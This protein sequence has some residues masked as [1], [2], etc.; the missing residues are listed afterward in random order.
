MLYRFNII[1]L[2]T[3]RGQNQQNTWGGQGPA[4]NVVQDRPAGWAGGQ[5][6]GGGGQ[7]RGGGGG[8]WSG[9][10]RQDRYRGAA[11]RGQGSGGGGGQSRNNGQ[12]GGARDRYNAYQSSGPSDMYVNVVATRA[13]TTIKPTTTNNYREMYHYQAHSCPK[14]DVATWEN[15]VVIYDNV[16]C[17]M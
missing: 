8:G 13:P 4:A 1:S 12:P 10:S 5:T 7:T 15:E 11:N 17:A 9:G 2:I 6:Q 16:N 14:M 3:G